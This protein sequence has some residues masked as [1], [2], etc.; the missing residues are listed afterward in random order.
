MEDGSGSPETTAVYAPLLPVT[1]TLEFLMVV[2]N[3]GVS[4]Y[5]NVN[6]IGI[7]GT[8]GREFDGN[9]LGRRLLGRLDLNRVIPSLFVVIV[10]REFR[11]LEAVPVE[12]FPSGFSATTFTVLVEA[13]WGRTREGIISVRYFKFRRPG[14]VPFRWPRNFHQSSPVFARHQLRRDSPP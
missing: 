4:F 6:L 8:L 3:L 2:L 13:Y 1:L 10:H 5:G 9:G 7:R 14:A 12:G 11:R